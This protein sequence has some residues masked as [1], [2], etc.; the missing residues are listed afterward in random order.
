MA[1]Y[2]HFDSVPIGQDCDE[3]ELRSALIGFANPTSELLK[4]NLEETSGRER[5]PIYRR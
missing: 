4:E 3:V 2:E 5:C 1:S